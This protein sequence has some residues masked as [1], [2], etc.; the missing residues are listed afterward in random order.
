MDE[1]RSVVEEA[2]AGEVKRSRKNRSRWSRSR[3]RYRNS[4]T[5][6]VEVSSGMIQ[7]FLWIFCA[8]SREARRKPCQ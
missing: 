6:K 4:L 7:A 3:R 1:G 8:P 5:L 2:F